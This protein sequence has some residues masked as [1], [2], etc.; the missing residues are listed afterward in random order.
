[1]SIASLLRRAPLLHQALLLKSG[2]NGEASSFLAEGASEV[3]D[4]AFPG[5]PDHLTCYPNASK[6]ASFGSEGCCSNG[7]I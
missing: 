5:K 3:K 2:R 1:M 4:R 7:N 6:F